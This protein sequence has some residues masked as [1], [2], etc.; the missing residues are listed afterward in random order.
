MCITSTSVSTSTST[1]TITSTSLSKPTKI[2]DTHDFQCPYKLSSL[3]KLEESH[4]FL[5]YWSKILPKQTKLKTPMT[6]R[7][8]LYR[9]I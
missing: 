2:E 9:N 6:I 5:S 4:D 1:S 8:I 7:A 3:T